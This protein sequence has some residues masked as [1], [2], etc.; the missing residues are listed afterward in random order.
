MK[1]ELNSYEKTEMAEKEMNQT[2]SIQLY[3]TAL[4]HRFGISML[5]KLHSLLVCK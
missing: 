4:E 2:V 3:L 1:V 5:S